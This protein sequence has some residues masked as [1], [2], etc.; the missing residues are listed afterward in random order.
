MT[1]L[2]KKR[3]LRG[4]WRRVKS[5]AAASRRFVHVRV[6][7]RKIRPEDILPP[8]KFVRLKHCCVDI[9][10]TAQFVLD[11]ILTLGCK[12][13]ADSALETR[14]FVGPNAKVTVA[15]DF[16]VNNGSDIRVLA[17]GVLAL[18]EG[19]CNDGVQIVCAKN[20]TIGRGCAIAR[21]V[22]IRDYDAHQLV[23]HGHEMAKD[24][25]IGE[26]VWIGTRAMILKGVTIGDNTIIGAGSVVVHDIPGN[27]LTV[28]SPA[29]TLE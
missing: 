3:V 9:D 27:S 15:G 29:G 14:F 1:G 28:G 23:G 2:P 16:S 13:F 22:I 26:H 24:I 12:A 6:L 17:N 4:C 11:G 18:N 21:D 8:T 19:F 20:V 7:G 25:V 5:L 10:E